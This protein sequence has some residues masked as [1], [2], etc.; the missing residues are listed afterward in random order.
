MLTFLDCGS[1]KNNN[2]YPQP[3]H[4]SCIRETLFQSSTVLKVK[5]ESAFELQTLVIWQWP[6]YCAVFSVLVYWAETIQESLAQ[7]ILVVTWPAVPGLPHTGAAAGTG[8]PAR[9]WAATDARTDPAGTEQTRRGTDT[10]E[11]SGGI[12]S[13][14]AA[15]SASTATEYCAGAACLLI[16]KTSYLSLFISFIASTASLNWSGSNI[17]FSFLF[18]LSCLHP[19]WYWIRPQSSPPHSYPNSFLNNK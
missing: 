7:P 11:D 13:Q 8:H 5:P 19:Q 6:W 10:T 16:C 9:C 1:Y 3:F 12:Q 4:R 14:P 17:F 18:S 15:L 2:S